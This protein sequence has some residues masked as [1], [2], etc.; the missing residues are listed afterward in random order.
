MN[1]RSLLRIMGAGPLAAAQVARPGLSRPADALSRH[2]NLFNGDSCVYFYNPELW[3]PEGGP[4]S[5]KAIHRY[6][7][8]LAASGIDTFLINPNAQVAWYPSK[9]LQTVIDGYRRG[10]RE[11]FRGH[12][13]AVGVKPEKMDEHLDH[14]VKFFNM[15]LDLV[16]QGVD[17]LAETSKA[18][19]AHGVSPWVSCRMN[20]MH[21]A[22]NPQGSHFNCALFKQAKFRLSGRAMDPKDS[23]HVGWMGLNYEHRE[24]REFMLA[25][26]GEWME[27]YEFDGLELDWL[28]QPLCCEPIA[29]R[30]QIDLMVDWMREVRGLTDARARRIG[31]PVPLGLRIP[32][33]L[34]YMKNI[35]IDVKAQVA[36]GLVD[37]I[38]FT[39]AW[40]TTWSVPYDELRKELGPDV[41]FI[42][43]VEDA[44][45]WIR[46]FAPSLA[47]RSAEFP[48]ANLGMRYMAASPPMQWANAAGKLTMGVHGIEQFNFFCTDQPK[49][50]GLR[51]NYSALKGTDDLA[52][53]RGRPKH[54]CLSTPSPW[55]SR[56]IDQP[57]QLP[58]V[59]RPKWR[60]EFRLSMCAEPPRPGLELIAQVVIENH[61]NP[62]PLGVSLNGTWPVF[63]RVETR[64]LVFPTGPYTQHTSDHLGLNFRLDATQIRDGWNTVLVTNETPESSGSAVTI[65]SLELSVK[66]I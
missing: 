53:L 58:A 47:D 14:Q 19:R 61:L 46:G 24:V 9:K 37:F 23:P 44:P 30:K 42:G 5:A 4:Y 21:G 63:E 11:F 48:P 41:V 1:R 52:R 57:E 65:V 15:Y 54:Y 59:L 55:L 40:Q 50:P 35:G 18:C 6:V 31:K 38:G 62:P 17:W 22:A 33:N 2:R 56:A 29:G 64:D 66:A 16:E 12:A 7:S 28:R 13:L 51:C 36:A 49:I 32:V 60:K 27:N 39:D 8:L 10:D 3:Q 20:D 45:N 34:G 26:I 43:V 25:N